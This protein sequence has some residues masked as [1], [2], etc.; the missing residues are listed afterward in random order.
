MP[1]FCSSFAGDPY[2]FEVMRLITRSYHPGWWVA[3]AAWPLTEVYQKVPLHSLTRKPGL[4][5]TGAFFG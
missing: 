1:I 5:P 2:L 3:A 4:I